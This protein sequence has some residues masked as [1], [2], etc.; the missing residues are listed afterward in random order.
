M[1]QL[2]QEFPKTK[3]I[4]DTCGGKKSG[5]KG[6]DKK[7]WYNVNNDYKVELKKNDT[8]YYCCKICGLDHLMMVRFPSHCD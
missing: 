8:T 7:T 5:R 4:G 1:L 3:A 2:L 6:D